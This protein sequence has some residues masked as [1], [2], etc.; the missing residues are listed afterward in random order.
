[1]SIP[2]EKYYTYSDYLTWDDDIRYELIDGI[3]YAMAGASRAHQEI[4]SEIHG[5]LYMFLRGEPC[6]S[7]IPPF[8]VRLNAES[9]D[10]IVVQPDI[11]VVCDMDKLDDKSCIGSPDMIVEVIS[12]SS[13]RHDK[14]TKYQ[15]YQN[16]GVREYWII[17][18][19][20]Q[21]V[22]AHVLESG[23]YIKSLYTQADTAPVHVLEGCRI[24]LAEVFS[25]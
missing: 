25:F 21:T 11:M 14:E 1:M 4:A 9:Y 7:Y 13:K 16:A 6:K 8:D 20:E 2:L 5:Q 10:D 15:I 18:P 3:P 19:A 24:H 17:D 23:K 22:E 12:P